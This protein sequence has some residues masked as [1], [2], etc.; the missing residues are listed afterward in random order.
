MLKRRGTQVSLAIGAG[1][2]ALLLGATLSVT[3]SGFTRKWQ[4]WIQPQ[5]SSLSSQSQA[6][7]SAVAALADLSP[8][9]RATKLAAIAQGKQG[10]DR[11]RARYLLASDAIRQRQGEKALQWLK[12]LESDYPELAAYVAFKQ[13]QAYTISGKT[14]E[15]AAAW[16]SLLRQYPDHPIAA[17]ALFVLGRQDRQYWDQAIAKFPT[18]PRTQ[19]IIRQ[20]LRQNPNQPKLLLILAKYGINAPGIVPVL[21]RLTENPS[22]TATLQPEDWEAIAF[23]Y[24]EHQEYG[25]AAEAYARAPRNSLNTYRIGR[26]LQLS[27]LNSQAYRAYQLLAT[28]FPQAEET[29][30]ALI[31]MAQLTPKPIN[32]IPYL[33]RVISQFPDQAA[34]ALM[35]KADIL[36]G[37]GSGKSAA[38]SRQSVLSQYP[39][40]D[41]AAE[42]RWKQAQRQANTGNF[43]AA[44][45]WAEPITKQNSES[46]FA[47]EAAYWVGK[48]ASQIGR[49]QDATSAFEYVLAKY[50]ES[51]YAWRSAVQLGWNVGDFDSV[52]QLQPQVVRSGH[53]SPLPTGS[54]TLQE[55]YQLGQSQDAWA[56]WQVE[57][58]NPT[59]PTVAEQFTDGVLRVGVGDHLDGI[60][61]LSSLAWREK[62]EERSQYQTLKQQPA[63]W[64]AL[65]PFPFLQP[66][67]A[68]SQERQLNPLLVTALIRQESRF[69]PQIR[70]VVGA[71]GLMQV[72]PETASWIASQ[73]KLK[74]YKLDK[75]E[76]NIKLGTW[77]LAYTH[78]E[79]DNNSLFAVASYN[80]GPGAVAGWVDKNTFSDLDQF[81]EAIP[82]GETKGYVKSVFE[83]YWNYLRLYNP[84]VS[85][86]VEQVA[87][88]SN[89]YQSAFKF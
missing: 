55:L 71:T 40:S 22:F 54:A 24:W 16:K 68:W 60:F 78:R 72:M 32:G 21:N 9:Q 3:T 38:Q 86:Q 8:E 37:L 67:E 61:M 17:E 88:A 6:A 49:E 79:Y 36:E 42:I 73:I 25:K 10:A 59:K 52:R 20:R 80:A 43:L 4:S 12:G 69:Q 31:R 81:V 75:P 87:Q 70:S 1:L 34:E 57:F 15:A 2:C 19:D 45:Q 7:D 18:Y 33:D 41:A 26:G 63:F 56:L 28:A 39:K 89:S 62:T 51:Y 46:E 53:S 44:W 23:N 13:A 82:Y 5:P 77:Y 14:A 66:I 65:Y 58:K 47:P 76:D 11:N 74:Q 83:N 48:W 84:E 35:V 64:Q 50:P 30:T 29:A 27:G 85:Q